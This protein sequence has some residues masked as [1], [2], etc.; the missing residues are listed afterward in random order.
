MS[1]QGLAVNYFDGRS[2]RAQ[3]AQ[4]WLS[5]DLLHVRVHVHVNAH[6][7]TELKYPVK[8][9]RWPERQRHG[10][11]LALL[12]DGG[13]LSCENAGAWDAWF[14]ASGR[15]EPITVSWMQSWR[16]VAL[17]LAMLVALILAS[18]RWSAPMAAGVMLHYLPPGVDRQVGE[19]ALDYVDAHLL[20]PSKLPMVQQQ[21][22]AAHFDSLVAK[23]YANGH[24]PEFRLHFRAGG[25]TMGPNAFALPGGDIVL[26]DALVDLMKDAP[27]AVQG[28]LAHELG[29]VRHRHGMRMVLQA[30]V[31]AGIAGM[32]VGD[33]STVLAGVP[34]LLAQLSY[35]RGFEHDADEESRGMLLSAGISPRVMVRFFERLDRRR[36]G[37]DVLPIA[38][39]SHPANAERIA[40][41]SE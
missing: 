12:P 13:V 11:R 3:P 7:L 32:V 15:R 4:A 30:S 1:A 21:Q 39:S 31:V 22:I 5:D 25:K 6:A 2:A 40:F 41:F 28:V 9:V 29:H 20:T 10:Q 24:A 14:V 27:D 26:T 37:P 35:S 34:A 18:L 33:F 17:S 19:Q 36:D 23:Y 8:G 38:F 16:H